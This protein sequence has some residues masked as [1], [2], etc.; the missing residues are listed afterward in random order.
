VT[1]N[2]TPPLNDARTFTVTV[3]S[4]PNLEIALVGDVVTVTWT[5]IA[6]QTYRVQYKEN[7]DDAAWSDLTPDVTA[8]GSTASTT[9]TITSSSQHFYRVVVLP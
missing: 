1:D 5:A 7:L 9:D 2:G 4:D 3:V 8:S 6:G